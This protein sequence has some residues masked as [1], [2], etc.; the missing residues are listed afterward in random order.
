MVP[1]P[2]SSVILVGLAGPRAPTPSAG[3]RSRDWQGMGAVGTYSL[4]VLC[5]P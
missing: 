3:S 4:P 5:E 1:S 2:G